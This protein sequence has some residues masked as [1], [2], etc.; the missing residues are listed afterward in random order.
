MSR[1]GEALDE[2]R[3][4]IDS[5]NVFPVRDGDTGTNLALT[6][7]AVRESLER[8]PPGSLPEAGPAI[9][10]AALMGARGNSGVILAQFLRG[11]CDR[12]CRDDSAA[13]EDLVAALEQG[14]AEARRAVAT[15]LGGTALTV[16]SEAAEAARTADGEGL[17]HVALAAL[18]G[19]RKASERTREALPE[20][21]AAGLVDAGG[22]GMVLFFDGMW[23]VLAGRARQEAVGPM[24]PVGRE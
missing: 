6:Q 20:L 11:F 21:S 1:F 2:H 7:R 9:A 19:S 13:A 23:S 17:A 16:L 5:L 12:L 3:E 18:E 4:E 15:P 24:G 10:R 22:R 8:E 14:V